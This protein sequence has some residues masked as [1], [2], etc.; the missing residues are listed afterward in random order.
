MKPIAYVA[1]P[2]GF[3]E[4]GRLFYEVLKELIAEAGFE[5][6]DPWTLTPKEQIDSVQEL[7]YGQEKKEACKQM[8]RTIG[9]NNLS[10]I[11]ESNF[12]IAVLDGTDVDSG[13]AVEIGYG[14]G[15]KEITI[16]GYRN[17]F[18]VSGENEETTVN[19]QVEHCINISGGEIVT[20]LESLKIALAKYKKRFPKN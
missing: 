10:A 20:D 12:I 17:D 2:F 15:R 6:R 16:I 5:I 14:L 18:R 8:N 19:L 9:E 3:S 1:S 7:P 13:V 11:D 4:A